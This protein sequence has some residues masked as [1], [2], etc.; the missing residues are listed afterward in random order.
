[1]NSKKKELE[2]EYIFEFYDENYAESL[3]D[4]PVVI[5]DYKEVLFEQDLNEE[6]LKIIN[7]IKGPML[8][9]AGAGS[10]KTRTITYSVAKL[11]L[12]GVKPSEIMLVTFTNKAANEM[13]RRVETLLGKRP[14]GIWGGTFHSIANRFI[15]RYA[16]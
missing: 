14:K 16:K 4:T 9:I 11:L 3:E 5:E 2:E 7:N 1:M 10:G 13:I 12:S 15:R 6:Q 8:V